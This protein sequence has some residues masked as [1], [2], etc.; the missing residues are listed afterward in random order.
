MA[1]IA[2]TNRI[3]SSTAVS[4]TYERFGGLCAIMCGVSGFLYSVAFVILR[5]TSLS[6]LF[7]LLTGLLGTATLV[8]IYARLRETDVSFALWALLLGTV[9]ALGSALH[10]GYD[11]ANALN[12]PAT[13]NL[14]LPSQID[15][16]GMLTFGVAGLALWVMAWLILRGV[17]FPRGL[18]YLGYVTA[19]LLIIIYLARL[20]VLD[21]T[22]PLV[23]V[24]ALLAGFVASPVWY[25]WLGL[26]LWRGARA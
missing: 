20:I 22:S 14:D 10:A 7:L 12:P 8:A 16:R 26:N 6:A 3:G 17:Q 15:P 23:L 4:S 1:S 11:L 5:S 9:S 25:V 18:G 19:A 24:P 21:A 13:T 2:A